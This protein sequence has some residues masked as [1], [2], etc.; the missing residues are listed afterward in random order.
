M[1]FAS[2]KLQISVMLNPCTCSQESLLKC[3]FTL[4][5]GSNAC[6]MEKKANIELVDSNEGDMCINMEW[7]AFG[8]DGA[9]N[10]FRT[11][12]DI[13]CDTHSLNIGKQT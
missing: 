11:E 7:G 10:E 8:D 12:Y 3:R 2:S 4:G 6:Y 9:L 13:E 5:T 1:F